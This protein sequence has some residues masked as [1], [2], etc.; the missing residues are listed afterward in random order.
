MLQ[1]E[2]SQLRIDRGYPTKFGIDAR[3][4][5]RHRISAVTR[6]EVEGLESDEAAAILRTE[7]EEA[8]LAYYP[9][10]LDY[11]VFDCIVFCGRGVTIGWVGIALLNNSIRGL[12]D[13]QG[14]AR[15]VKVMEAGRAS[16]AIDQISFQRRRRHKSLPG[17]SKYMPTWT[18]RVTRVQRRAKL[19]LLPDVSEKLMEKVAHG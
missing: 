9:D 15:A 8:K 14:A 3:A 5:S 17:W 18:N 13:E 7:W 6:Q 10:G 19:M 1:E 4:L 2:G 12:G 16:L 11:F